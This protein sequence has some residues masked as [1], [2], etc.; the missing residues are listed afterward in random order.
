MVNVPLNRQSILLTMLFFS[1]LDDRRSRKLSP[2]Y[3]SI[4]SQ[5]HRMRQHDQIDRPSARSRPVGINIYV[6]DFLCGQCF[7]RAA[8]RTCT[9]MAVK[10]VDRA[11]W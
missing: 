9:L 2:A 5:T 4:P 10:I 11:G 1:A 8:M 7:H 6:F 3:T